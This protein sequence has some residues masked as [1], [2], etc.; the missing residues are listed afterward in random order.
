[1]TPEQALAILREQTPNLQAPLQ[2][3]MMVQQAINALDPAQ[4][5]VVEVPAK[6]AKA[7]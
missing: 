5:A 6:G 7:A 4:Q 3:H 2:I 1:M